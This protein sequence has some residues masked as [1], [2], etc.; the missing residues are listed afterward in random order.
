MPWARLEDGYFTHRKVADLSKD[1]KLVDLAAIAFS[2]RELRDGELTRADV[3]IVAAQVD[4]GDP[5]AVA[6]ELVTAGRWSRNER[7]YVIH[8]YLKYNPS[9][10]QVL[11]EREAGAK[12]VAEW[13]ANHPKPSRKRASSRNA[14]TTGEVHPA[15]DPDPGPV[16]GI[17]TRNPDPDSEPGDAR[18]TRESSESETER[19][20][21]PKNGVARAPMGVVSHHVAPNGEV[22]FERS[23]FNQDL[24]VR[25][26]NIGQ[27]FDDDNVASSITR[28]QRYQAAA[29]LDQGTMAHAI[30]DAHRRTLHRLNNLTRSPPSSPMAYFLA[31]LEQTT[32]ERAAT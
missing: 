9:R 5:F 20:R 2:A 31:T 13:R 3:R 23:E 27:Q 10:Q 24:A 32:Q 22:R 8:D 15:P 29:H 1:A 17:E 21:P 7:G 18:A 14:V 6:E 28:A 12:R 26:E 16:P 25:I 4:V 11:K 30:K 19:M